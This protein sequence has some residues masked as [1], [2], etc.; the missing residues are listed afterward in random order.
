ILTGDW[1]PFW[2]IK[3]GACYDRVMAERP[4]ACYGGTRELLRGADLRIVNLECAI[5]GEKP[6][7]KSGPHL[8]AYERHLPCLRA[9][10][11]EVAALANN[12]VFD[13]GAEGFLKTRATLD[14]L[15]IRSFGAGM[16]DA[17]AWRPLVCDAGGV[18]V[19]LV[20]F[21]EG[22]DLSSAAPGKPGV[23]GWE[24]ARARAAIRELKKSCDAVIVIPHGGI[25]FA[26][27]PSKYCIDAYRELAAEHPAAIVAHHTHVPQGI[28]I[29]DGVPIF[30]SLGN[31]L[32]HH[33]TPLH[34]RRH[35]FLAELEV[36]KDGLHGFRIHP[37]F[38]GQEGLEVL[39]GEKRAGF[40]ATLRRVSRPFAAGE[41]PYSGFY[42]T[43]KY[44]WQT[45]PFSQFESIAKFFESDPVKA[46]AMLR[47]RL[48]TL[49]N[50]GLT[51]PMY[52]RVAKGI[53]D[54]APDWA[55]EAEREYM[56]REL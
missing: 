26:A 45:I 12:H 5:E 16:D 41:D 52:D 6:V 55:V 37:F 34:F 15:G 21:T 42:A 28:E 24:V 35:G 9:G 27:H 29:H 20:G 23:A 33:M 18:R 2:D 22:H 30:Y 13:Y 53:I 1:V 39:E 50:I 25:E 4:E 54:D 7:V 49:Q 17:E 3:R 44:R 36:A 19:G 8:C 11:F 56:T 40:L 51:V 46:A 14:K 47:S 48:T 10:G 38:I 43:L 32:F 31:Y